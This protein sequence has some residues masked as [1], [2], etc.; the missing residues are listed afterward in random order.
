MYSELTVV[1]VQKICNLLLYRRSV[2]YT[3][4]YTGAQYCIIYG[5][6]TVNIQKNCNLLLHRGS[7]YFTCEYTGARFSTM[8]IVATVV[9]YRYIQMLILLYS[10]YSI[11]RNII[12]I[13]IIMIL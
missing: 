8:Y 6:P 3:C 9:L 2:Y 11:M 4:D 13:I 10:N 12:I 7:V 5:V 1:D